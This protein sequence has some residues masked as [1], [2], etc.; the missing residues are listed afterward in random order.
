MLWA[1]SKHYDPCTHFLQFWC[2][3]RKFST[4]FLQFWYC[5]S[6]FSTAVVL[7]LVLQTRSKFRYCISKFRYCSTKF[8][9]KLVLVEI[10][11]YLL[12]FYRKVRF[13]PLRRLIFGFMFVFFK[14]G[15]LRER[16]IWEGCCYACFRWLYF[17]L[18]C[19]IKK[20]TQPRSSSVMYFFVWCRTGQIYW[21][22][23][24]FVHIILP[25]TW[26]NMY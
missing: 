17:F 6:K 8:K 20:K 3:N 21:N 24:P 1:A 15:F 23:L 10:L 12:S 14:Y 26:R 11:V 5:S 13:S 7:N 4:H 18:F 22:M 9:N 25:G 2:C 16:K 19:F